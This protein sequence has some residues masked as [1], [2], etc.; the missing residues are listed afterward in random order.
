MYVLGLRETVAR[1]W[2]ERLEGQIQ[3]FPRRDWQP[4]EET[5]RKQGDTM[6]II[7]FDVCYRHAFSESL[8]GFRVSSGEFGD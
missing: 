5:P 3:E 4:Q 1:Q 2:S 6:C 7:V 8:L